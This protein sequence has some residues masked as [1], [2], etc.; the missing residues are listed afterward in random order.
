MTTT[1]SSNRGG[2]TPEV[3]AA[4]AELRDISTWLR[5]TLRAGE[6]PSDGIS[7][8]RGVT[9]QLAELLDSDEEGDEL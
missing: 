3:Q 1:T 7:D 8:L 5:T 6:D 2:Y 9:E 4:L